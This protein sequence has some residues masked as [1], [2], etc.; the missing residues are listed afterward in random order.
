MYPMTRE[1]VMASISSSVAEKAVCWFD[2]RKK[3]SRRILR[4]L[5]HP[6]VGGRVIGGAGIGEGNLGFG[7]SAEGLCGG[8]IALISIAAGRPPGSRRKSLPG[9]WH[10]F[11]ESPDENGRQRSPTTMQFPLAQDAPAAR[12]ADTHVCA[13]WKPWIRVADA[14]PRPCPTLP[15]HENQ[16]GW[17]QTVASR[18]LLAASGR[19]LSR[20]RRAPPPDCLRLRDCAPAKHGPMRYSRW[21]WFYRTPRPTDEPALRHQKI[22]V[23]RS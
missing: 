6:A 1:S 4:R 2:G 9:F 17:L 3:R 15:A 11:P 13:S 16:Q 19:G 5:T 8:V 23:P 21:N 12:R 20:R 22:F 18:R 14:P 7:I 10:L